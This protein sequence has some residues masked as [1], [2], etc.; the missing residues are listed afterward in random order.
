[1]I[2]GTALVVSALLFYAIAL[3]RLY[4]I[5]ETR[6]GRREAT[7][8][9]LLSAGAPDAQ[10]ELRKRATRRRA[11]MFEASEDDAIERTRR[12]VSAALAIV[13]LAMLA[14]I[15]LGER[16]E[17]VLVRAA[18]SS[19]WWLLATIAP[20]VIGYVWLIDLARV[21]ASSTRHPGRMLASL[22]GFGASIVVTVVVSTLST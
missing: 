4:S 13:I 8:P 21:L 20:V 12:D 14:W 6:Q 15:P 10:A 11:L 17:A 22:A 2:V 3:T 19:P 9:Q 1:M 5:A 7:L 18:E 16:L